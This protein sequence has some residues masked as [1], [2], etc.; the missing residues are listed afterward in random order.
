MN[1]VKKFVKEHVM[2]IAVASAVVASVTGIV[3]AKKVV[4]PKVR[5]YQNLKKFWD[6]TVGS[7]TL[8][9]VSSNA[10]G[11]ITK[12]EIPHFETDVGN[13][14]D[15]WME[16]EMPNAI[17]GGVKV[18]DMGKVGS[19]FA[20]KASDYVNYDTVCDMVLTFYEN[21]GED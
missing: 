16:S 4:I 11:K 13:L 5:E 20:E 7:G 17:I 21:G 10:F 14:T 8:S 9:T 6:T 15:F 19:E 18:K 12:G 1:K 3:V 2:G